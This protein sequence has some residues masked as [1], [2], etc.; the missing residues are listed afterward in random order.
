M[1]KILFFCLI[2]SG[3]V[4][5]FNSCEKAT[6]DQGSTSINLNAPVDSVYFAADILPILS[7]N[8]VSCHS[9]QTPIMEASVAYANIL[10][11]VTIGSPETSVF[12]LK[13]TSVGTPHYSRASEAQK[14]KIYYWIKQGCEE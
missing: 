11:K 13:L 2:A 1:K 14:D 8:C 7:S 12:Y 3:M 10:T 6:I 5:L 9:S 4:V